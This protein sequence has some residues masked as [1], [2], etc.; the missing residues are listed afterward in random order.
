[1]SLYDEEE[2]A[3]QAQFN[4]MFKDAEILDS[5]SFP[6]GKD[7]VWAVSEYTS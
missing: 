3:K 7:K 4:Q 1:M 2:E 5:P 6:K